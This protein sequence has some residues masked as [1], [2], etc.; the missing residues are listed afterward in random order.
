M[1]V[2]SN[3]EIRYLLSDSKTDFKKVKIFMNKIH[4]IVVSIVVGC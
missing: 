2:S 3:Q 1:E 4:C